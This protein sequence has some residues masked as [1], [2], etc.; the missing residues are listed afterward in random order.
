MQELCCCTTTSDPIWWDWRNW[1]WWHWNLE[2][3]TPPVAYS[4]DLSPCDYEVFG[5][6]KIFPYYFKIMIFNK[7]SS[8]IYFL[9]PSSFSTIFQNSYNISKI[10]QFSSKFRN[11]LLPCNKNLLKIFNQY[12]LNTSKNTLQILQNVLKISLALPLAC[13]IFFFNYLEIFFNIF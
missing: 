9:L 3:L 6:L 5:L 2:V 7:N 13:L 8:K 1:C 4:P 11:T 12:S 10:Y